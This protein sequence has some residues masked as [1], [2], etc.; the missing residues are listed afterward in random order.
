MIN[1]R[2]VLRTAGGLGVVSAAGCLSIGDDGDDSPEEAGDDGE[3]EQDGGGDSDDTPADGED[4]ASEQEGD[5]SDDTS[6]NGGEARTVTTVTDGDR[7]EELLT[8]E[9]FATVGDIQ[10]TDDDTYRYFMNVEVNEV[11]RESFDEGLEAIGAYDAPEEAPDKYTIRTHVDGEVVVEMPLD[12]ELVEHVESGD[13]QG[14]LMMFFRKR[15]DAEAIRDAV[16]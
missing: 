8:T 11:G 14:K 15:E 3:T 13:W 2:R 4:G 5:D 1:R 16:Q 10:E 6:A 7:V 12:E 9:H